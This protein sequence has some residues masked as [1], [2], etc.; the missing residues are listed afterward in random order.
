[1]NALNA[2]WPAFRAL[3]TMT[4]PRPL[5]FF[6]EFAALVTESIE[7][8]SLQDLFKT[9]RFLPGTDGGLV[10]LA[11]LSGQWLRKFHDA[12]AVSPGR[13][14]VDDKL[15]SVRANLGLLQSAGFP[16]DLCEHMEA[17]FDFLAQNIRD[18]DLAVAAVHGDFTVDNV[19]F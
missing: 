14:D 10:R 19:L 5:D 12:T 1:Y 17:R 16:A 9:I 2:V 8:R 4:V 11:N 3:P 6:P 18:L 7:G 15:V 13:L